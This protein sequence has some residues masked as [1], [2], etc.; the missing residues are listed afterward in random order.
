VQPAQDAPLDETNLLPLL[1]AKAD[2]F[3][4]IFVLLHWGHSTFSS[5]LNTSS[6]KSVLHF[7]HVNSYI[8]MV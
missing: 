5:L 2:I 8:G 1:M 4:F 7:W 3:R 6:S